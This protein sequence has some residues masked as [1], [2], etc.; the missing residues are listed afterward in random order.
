MHTQ[1]LFCPAKSGLDPTV[2]RYISLELLHTVTLRNVCPRLSHA[3]V[4][5]QK[6]PLLKLSRSF[7]ALRRWH[8][9]RNRWPSVLCKSYSV[10]NLSWDL[11]VWNGT[12]CL[13]RINATT[14]GMK[15]FSMVSQI[16]YKDF[17]YFIISVLEILAF[18]F[19]HKMLPDSE[20]VFNNLVIW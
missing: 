15:P 3:L 13:R 16:L 9:G 8:S 10:L 18:L 4:T 17:W 12:M 5:S 14:A 11:T 2:Q 19:L 1:K 6:Q 20:W 7:E